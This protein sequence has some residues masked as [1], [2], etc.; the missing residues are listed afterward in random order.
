MIR[1]AIRKWL[2]VDEIHAYVRNIQFDPI[3]VKDE[4]SPERR[5]KSDRIAADVLAKLSAELIAARRQGG[6]L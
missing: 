2:G 4:L 6:Q 1:D 5:S 3:Y